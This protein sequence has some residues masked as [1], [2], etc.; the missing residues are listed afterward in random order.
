MGYPRPKILTE[1]TVPS[2]GWDLDFIVS[3]AGSLDTPLTATIP[4]GTYFISWDA[5]ADD[6][7]WEV[8]YRLRASIISAGIGAG[9][10]PYVAL[11]SD[12]KV[13]ISFRGTGF[14]GA[15]TN[16]VEITWTTSNADLA[17]ALG[18]DSTTDDQ[19]LGVDRPEFTADY[20]HAFGWYADA[21]GQL[22]S[23][24]TEDVPIVT[25][26]QAVSYTGQSM[27]QY[28]GERYTNELALQWLPRALT[29]SRGIGYGA[30]PLAPYQRNKGL[31]S[32][33]EEAKL[34]R[35]FRVYRDGRTD[36]GAPVDRMESTT[37]DNASV[38][39]AAKSMQ[40]DPA[41]HLGRLLLVLDQASG[42][43]LQ[44]RRFRITTQTA[45][46][47]T[48]PQNSP[49]GQIWIYATATDKTCLILDQRYETYVVDL[50]SMSS[51]AP[52]ERPTVDYYDITIPLLRY[53]S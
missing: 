43:G 51:F 16:D 19:S 20:Q 49:D 4:A 31:Q 39:D 42:A 46:A 1:I 25:T 10:F 30:S 52:I 23:L 48:S 17:A 26:P 2:G 33:W 53:E 13:V 7:L 22:A 29:H 38:T 37:S 34:G 45:T 15:P 40:T 9:R 32:W 47:V 41:E 11:D 5:Q 50:T 44:P 18:F 3:V 8:A 27:A 28:L 21:D 24:L 12:H 35:R 36:D 14:D 6:L